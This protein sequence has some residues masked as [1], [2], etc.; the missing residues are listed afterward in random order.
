MTLDGSSHAL[1]HN[2]AAVRYDTCLC[3]VFRWD[4]SVWR[5]VAMQRSE[6]PRGRME[7]YERWT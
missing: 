6:R 1:L 5:V 7:R 2:A 3:S 4:A